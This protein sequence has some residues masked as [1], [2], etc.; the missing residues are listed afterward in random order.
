MA[1]VSRNV[2]K[3]IVKECLIEILA[4]GL[5][6]TASAP[7]TDTLESMLSEAPKKKPG[8]RRKPRSKQPIPDNAA[9]NNAVAGSVKTLTDD[10]MMASIFADTAKTTLQEQLGAESKG[11]AL[12]DSAS[13]KMDQLDPIDAFGA[14]GQPDDHWARLAFGDSQPGQNNK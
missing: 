9:F 4:E 8:R 2:L 11:P 1:K 13:R 3:G 5:I 7:S 6:G 14:E 10:E 12:A